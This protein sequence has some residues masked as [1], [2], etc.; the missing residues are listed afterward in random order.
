MWSM[1]LALYQHTPIWTGF[2]RLGVSDTGGVSE[3]GCVSETR[4]V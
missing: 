4:G 2:A 1:G 3:T